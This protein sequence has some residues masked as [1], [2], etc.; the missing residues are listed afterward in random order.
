M[1]GLNGRN[2]KSAEPGQLDSLLTDLA[3][4]DIRLKAQDGKL[5]YDA[6]PGCFTDALK[7]R[8]TALRPALLAHL[9]RAPAQAAAGTA[10]V[11]PLSCGQ[12]RMWF[13]NQM[14]C[15]EGAG[16][17]AY[18]EHLAF[19]LTGPLDRRAMEAALSAL[20]ARHAALRSRFP[21]VPTV[22]SR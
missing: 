1:T 14:E 5:G 22:R 21:T 13:L 8:V 15:Q 9:D 16:T 19:D 2:G 3:A 7:R 18:T 12:E 4:L 20:T 11:A 6:P 17:G 10:A